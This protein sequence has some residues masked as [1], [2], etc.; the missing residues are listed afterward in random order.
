MI[1]LTDVTL[2]RAGRPLLEHADLTVH[3]GHRV[4]L[5]G[6]NGSGKS[7]LFAALRGELPPDAGTIDLPPRWTI[8]HVA[9]ETPP[10]S[11][12]AIEFVQDG[13]V[14]LREVER[15]LAAAG[16]AHSLHTAAAEGAALA[17]LH[18]R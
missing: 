5:V 13:D 14:E 12:P 15:A 2:A 16:A 17:E 6:P 11:T 10:L 3:A 8:A 9:Q 18:H 7:T 4:G 1:R